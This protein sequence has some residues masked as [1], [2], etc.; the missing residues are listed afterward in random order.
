M[1]HGIIIPDLIILFLLLFI[2]IFLSLILLS[3]AFAE[4]PYDCQNLQ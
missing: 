2:I 1:V 4:S 3:N